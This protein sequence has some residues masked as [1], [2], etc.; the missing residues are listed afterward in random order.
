MPAPG[1]FP[2]RAGRAFTV[3]LDPSRWPVVPLKLPGRAFTLWQDASRWPVRKLQLP[4][5][6]FTVW[7]D[8]ARWPARPLKLPGQGFTVW[9]NPASWPK[10]AAVSVLKTAPLVTE[11]PEYSPGD[12][13]LEE[14]PLSDLSPPQPMALQISQNKGF[15]LWTRPD[16]ITPIPM[17][18]G[19]TAAQLAG[20][21]GVQARVGA[22]SPR[23]SMTASDFGNPPA[24][25]S[26]HSFSQASAPV[27][28]AH[29]LLPL[30]A[31][32]VAVLGVHALIAVS[33]SRTSTAGVAGGGGV[34]AVVV[35]DQKELSDL[36]ARVSAV[37]QE[38]Q[39]KTM[40]FTGRTA[41]LQ[42]EKEQLAADL[43][44]TR[45]RER[46]AVE[47]ARGEEARVLK[48]TQELEQAKLSASTASNQS[49]SRV[50]TAIEEASKIKREAAAE[51]V[52]LRETLAKVEAEKAAA[53][54]AAAESAAALAALK[55]QVEAAAKP[56]P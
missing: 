43:A 9:Q 42:K 41:G 12:P 6:G 45:E 19:L 32:L 3:W 13:T 15:T 24:G 20:T 44:A 53:Q 55:S 35:Q 31:G 30:A 27:P 38:L 56:A 17:K 52:V 46:K 26:S 25:P 49:E 54:R 48:L 22:S 51:V 11:I 34:K 1:S 16:Q 14:D 4:G 5:R 47:A 2:P 50:M 28:F 40:Q 36:A 18:N 8:P 37:D 21:G 39:E 33:G 7:L 10:P 29:R 23:N